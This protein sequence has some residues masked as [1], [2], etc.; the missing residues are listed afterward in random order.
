ME[1]TREEVVDIAVGLVE[2]DVELEKSRIS[3]EGR[4]PR[5]WVFIAP[6]TEQEARQLREVF[7]DVG[8]VKAKHSAGYRWGCF[9]NDCLVVLRELIDAG[10]SGAPGRSQLACHNRHAPPEYPEHMTPRT[11]GASRLHRL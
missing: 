8:Y 1:L 3:D 2:L 9:G 5:P 11:P 7:G 4:L 6:D 10:L